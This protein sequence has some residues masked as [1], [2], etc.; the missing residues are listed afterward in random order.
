MGESR[1]EVNF[2]ND[3]PQNWLRGDFSDV[4]LPILDP[5]TGLAFPGNQIP[6]S[7][8]SKFA[9]EQLDTIPLANA[10][11]VNNYRVVRNYTDDTKTATL[12][13]DQVLNASHSF[14]E[15]YIW[16][17]SFQVLPGSVVDSGRPQQGKNLA[18]GHTWVV[19]QSVVNEFRAGYNYGDRKSTRLNSSHLVISYAVF[20]L[21]KKKKY[22]ENKKHSYVQHIP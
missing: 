1:G 11:G 9:T 4:A 7:R 2:V 14:F 20:Y 21:K 6:Q 19:S 3:P 16:Y 10:T 12:R 15:R 22:K 18:L 13:F 8:F 5:L 17:D